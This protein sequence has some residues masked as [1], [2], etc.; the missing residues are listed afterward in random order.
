MNS[1]VHRLT[2]NLDIRTSLI[3]VH[4]TLSTLAAAK[5]TVRFIWKYFL[6][7]FPELKRLYGGSWSVITGGSAGIGLEIAKLLIK[8]GI[9]VVLIARNRENL[10]K[11]AEELSL[12]NS[13]VEVRVISCDA[14]APNYAAVMKSLEDL[15][16][17][18]LVNNVGVHNDIP[19]NVEDMSPLE[20]CRIIQVN[21]SFQ[22]SLTSML[23]PQLRRARKATIINI[24]SLTSQMD[25]PML[26]VYAATKAF[27]THFSVCLAAEVQP[28]GIEVLC[29]RPGLTVSRMSGISTPT[30]FCPSA[31]DMAY[32]CVRMIG[33]GAQPSIA[34]Y[35]P[36]ALLDVVNGFVP[37]SLT[38]SIVRGM[39]QQK[40]EAMLKGK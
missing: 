7:P 30:L 31:A 36:H 35:W 37:R 24:S 23:L 1:L 8:H 11:V 34:P 39:H 22:V 19:S 16:I 38:W 9:N 14:A 10:S 15:D 4:L 18:L 5:V 6:R 40:R 12:L 20:I 13:A 2:N 29:L 28:L 27:E 21:C 25:M 26:S 33:C 3:W 17:S 32:C